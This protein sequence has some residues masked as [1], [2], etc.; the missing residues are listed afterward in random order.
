MLF[1]KVVGEVTSISCIRLNS[2]H[3]LVNSPIPLT[4]HD[5]LLVNL[6]GLESLLLALKGKD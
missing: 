3:S 5:A 2:T 1:K 6:L 4:N